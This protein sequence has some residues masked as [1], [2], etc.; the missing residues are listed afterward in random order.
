MAK[1]WPA[2]STISAETIASV[3]G[4]LMVKV[5]PSPATLFRSIV[6][7]IFSMLVLTTS[8]PTPRPLTAVTAAAVEKPGWKMKRC[9]CASG[10][11][12][13]SPWV[14]RPCASALA[15][16]RAT[17]R[18][19]PSSAISMTMWPPSWNAVRVMRPTSGLPAA[20]REA[21]S[22]SP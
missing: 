20:R 16:M 13:S 8:I 17:S 12:S 7:P 6:P 21:A 2:A 10:I 14:A 18:P 11:A 15:R 22:S 1:R 9:N 5:L 19:R 4:I 3:S